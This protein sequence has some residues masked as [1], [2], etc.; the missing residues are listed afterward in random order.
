MPNPPRITVWLS[1]RGVQANP[2]RGIDVAVVLVAKTGAYAAESLRPAGGKVEWVGLPV[3]LVEQIEDG[4][5]QAQVQGEIL[6]PLVFVLRVNKVI[7]LAQSVYRQCACQAGFFDCVVCQILHRGERKLSVLP[8]FLVHLNVAD[9]HS[10]FDRMPVM[11]PGQV[12]DS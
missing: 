10:G 12:V 5:A 3:L 9:L 1:F 6:P 8:V 11:N 2:T 7:V 4:V